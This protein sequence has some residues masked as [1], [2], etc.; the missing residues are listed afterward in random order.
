MFKNIGT[1]VGDAISK[2]FKNVINA[3]IT[4]VEKILNAPIKAINKLI[5]VVN[6]LPGVKL[7]KLDTFKLPRLAKGTI[8]NNPGR[9]VPI[10]GAI[11]GESGREAVLPLSDARLLEELGS[12]I[13]RYITINLTNV[14]ELDGTTIARKMKNLTN[15]DNFL[16]NR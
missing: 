16:R 8:L 10:G 3:V 7:G 4:G 13:G 5:D 11:A 12:T 14:T 1:K 9:G 6:E 15:N 2:A